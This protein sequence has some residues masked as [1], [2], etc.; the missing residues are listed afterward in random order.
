[1]ALFARRPRTPRVLPGFGLSLGYT[2][3]YLSVVVLLPMAALVFTSATMGWREFWAEATSPGVMSAYRLTFGASFLA[4]VFNAGVGLLVAWVL[5]R[6]A[7]RGKRVVDAMIDLPF[8]MPTAVAGIALGFLYSPRGWMGRLLERLGFAYPWP[9]W[10]GFAE[11]GGGWRSPVG[12]EW[13]EAVSMA[14]LG[15]VVAMMF[16]GL[17]FVVRTLQPVI[18]DMERE[19]EEAAGCLGAT[20]LQ[21]FARVIFPQMVPALLTGF[22]LAFARGLGEYGSV[23]FI[24]KREPSTSIAAHEIVARL[25]MHQ[26]VEATAVST[27]LLLASLATLLAINIIQ[28]RAARRGMA[29]PA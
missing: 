20:R 1:M 2:V 15:V 23:I 29:S 4:A 28:R 22:A 18:E 9:H 24:A 19:A 26:Y 8:A 17:P 3:T 6:Y 5:A 21:T 14:P 12:F 16:V 10:R 25:D 11:P 13:F 7:F 27:F